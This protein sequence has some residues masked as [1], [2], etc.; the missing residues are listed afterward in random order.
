MAS[1]VVLEE[2]HKHCLCSLN[3]PSTGI[4]Y[5]RHICPSK[6]SYLL[7]IDF[8]S[9]MVV[10]VQFGNEYVVVVVVGG[11]GGGVDDDDDVTRIC[12][13]SCLTKMKQSGHPDD[14]SR[15]SHRPLS[16][17]RTHV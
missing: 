7:K 17:G 9:I 5:Y 4:P 11:G 8:S 12:F 15:N 13:V 6:Y 3:V 16:F 14:G 10:N 1:L 2:Q